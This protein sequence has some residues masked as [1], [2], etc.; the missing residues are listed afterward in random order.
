M[1]PSFSG[2][3]IVGQ[4]TSVEVGTTLSTPATFTWGFNTIGN[5]TANTMEIDDVTGAA[6]LASGLSLTP[7]SS[8]AIG[9][10]QLTAPGS[11]Q[12]KGQATNTHAVVFNSSLFTV[13]WFWMVY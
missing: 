7:T 1:N 4:S 12:W 2:F 8:Q 9:T 5:V 6:T 10:I 11:Y 13:S 3:S